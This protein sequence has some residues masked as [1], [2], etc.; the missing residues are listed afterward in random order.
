M[1]VPRIKI[2]RGQEQQ[3]RIQADLLEARAWRRW[4]LGRS[5]CPYCIEIVNDFDWLVVCDCLY[6]Q[7]LK[8]ELEARMRRGDLTGAP[9]WLIDPLE[10]NPDWKPSPP[11]PPNFPVITTDMIDDD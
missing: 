3:E 4:E 6:D 5:R 7:E 8:D 9:S 1:T 11:G 10:P 2:I